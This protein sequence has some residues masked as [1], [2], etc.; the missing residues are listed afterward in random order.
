MIKKGV[1]FGDERHDV[2]EAMLDNTVHGNFGSTTNN[3]R[4]WETLIE[5]EGGEGCFD[6]YISLDV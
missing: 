2:W 6:T 1:A 5:G 4:T 3:R